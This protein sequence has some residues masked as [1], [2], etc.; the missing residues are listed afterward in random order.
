MN[1]FVAFVLKR[2]TNNRQPLRIT[3]EL[4]H[5]ICTDVAVTSHARRSI[6]RTADS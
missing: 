1:N 2:A 6:L 4:H 3:Q 5:Q